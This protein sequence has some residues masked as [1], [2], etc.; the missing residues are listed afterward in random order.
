MCRKQS[1]SSAEFRLQRK[2]SRSASRQ[3]SSRTRGQIW[4]FEGNPHCNGGL[5]NAVESVGNKLREKLWIGTLGTCTD[6]FTEGTRQDI[7]AR[8]HN[9]YNG[10]P[11]WI[12]DAEFQS[13]YD[14]FCHQVCTC[15]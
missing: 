8:M 13:Y 6:G 3:P 1:S 5:K 7:D 12:P 4:H 11:V 15:G 10:L 9:E 14:E 2:H